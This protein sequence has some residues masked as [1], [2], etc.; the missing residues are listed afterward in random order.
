V[1]DDS[2]II[3]RMSPVIAHPFKVGFA[4]SMSLVLLG[5]GCVMLL[6]CLILL[7]MP[8]VE[9]RATSASAAARADLERAAAEQGSPDA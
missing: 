8:A 6:A 7:L 9:L 2:S 3:N 5:G 1:Q 4:D